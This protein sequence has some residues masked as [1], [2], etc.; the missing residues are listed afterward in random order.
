MVKQWLTAAYE[1]HKAAELA[2]DRK[3]F[4]SSVSRAY[5]ALYQAGT[6]LMLHLGEVP[7][8]QGNWSHP[9]LAT[10]FLGNAARRA[11]GPKAILFKNACIRTYGV[12]IGADYAPRFRIGSSESRE[13]RRWAGM[14]LRKA[15]EVTGYD[16]AAD[17]Q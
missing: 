13:A 4:R 15:V 2:S 1:S 6:A 9:R 3:L 12:R 16:P 5:Y 7:P 17:H 8:S 14:I 10:L 11:L